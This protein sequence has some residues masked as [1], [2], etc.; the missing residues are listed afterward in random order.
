MNFRQIVTIGLWISILD[1]VK[2]SS[3]STIAREPTGDQVLNR[4]KRVVWFPYN[5]G[6]GVMFLLIDI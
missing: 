6:I 4:S 1:L 2:S 3:N 5:Y